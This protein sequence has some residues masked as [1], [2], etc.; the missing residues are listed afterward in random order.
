MK[1]LEVKDSL[2]LVVDVQERL[3]PAMDAE[4]L[5]RMIRS[6]KVLGVAQ[7]ALPFTTLVSE[8]YPKGLGPTISAVQEAFGD[9]PRF[10][11]TSFSVWGDEGLKEAIQ[12]RSP[13]SVVI[14]GMETHICV[15]QS[16]RDLVQAGYDVW[17]L[18][19]GV[20]SRRSD[21]VRHGLELVR[22]AGAQVAPVETILFDWLG[23]AGGDAFKAISRALR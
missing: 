8:Q 13:R 18:S 11:K 6:L 5:G 12:A 16:A 10:D 21:N 2:L 4:H 3:A 9:A 22:S 17:V 19:D 14:A 23:A 20:A 7:D 15:F 1:R